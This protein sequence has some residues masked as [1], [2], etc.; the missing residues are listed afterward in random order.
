[1]PE[2][3]HAV[4]SK[5]ANP[6][7]LP[8]TDP[9]FF[10][11]P[12]DL[13]LHQLDNPIFPTDAPPSHPFVRPAVRNLF[14]VKTRKIVAPDAAQG[15]NRPKIEAVPGAKDSHAGRLHGGGVAT[16][17]WSFIRRVGTSDRVADVTVTR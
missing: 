1:M 5:L 16:H 17:S 8:R 7:L 2:R 13:G 3:S 11:F 15:G 10:P 14:I 4:Q 12:Q 6:T 9:L